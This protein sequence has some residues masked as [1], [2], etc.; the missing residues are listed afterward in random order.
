MIVE[1]VLHDA[2][3][4]L[5]YRVRN[6]RNNQQLV[7]KTLQ[8]SMES[9]PGAIAALLMEEWRA[10]RVVSPFFRRWSP[11]SSAVACIT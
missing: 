11:A 4:T 3:E 10:R 9:D 6:P 8:P 1:E 5:L 7:L 2:R